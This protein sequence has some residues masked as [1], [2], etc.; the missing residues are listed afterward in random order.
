MVD[1]IRPQ[2]LPPNEDQNKD[3]PAKLDAEPAQQARED[4]PVQPIR[5]YADTTHI[6]NEQHGFVVLP[7][8]KS[9]KKNP[10]K[11]VADKFNNLS[12]KQKIIT[13]IALVLVVI[14]AGGGV[15]ALTRDKPA[16]PPPP[17]VVE[18]KVEKPKPTTEASSLTGV[19]VPIGSNKRPITSIQI[20]NSPDARPQSGLRDAGVVF[21]AI[22]EGGITRFNA[23]FQEAKP[24]YIGP[25]RSVR[26]YYAELAA[27]FDPIFVHAGGSAAGLAKLA[28]LQ[29][30]DLD[31]GAN[32]GAF[33]R[34][35][36]RYAPHNLYSSTAALDQ[37][38]AS[39][40]YTKSNA[41]G[42]ER[43]A[44]K[45]GQPVKA[46]TINMAISSYLYNTTYNYDPAANN[47]QRVMAGQPHTDH[48]S[49]K[50]ITPKVVI[51]I[52]SSFSQN[53]IYS[54]YQTSGAGQVFIFQDG[55][56]YQGKWHKPSPRDRITFTDAANKAIKINAGQTWITL[57]KDP[58]QVSFGP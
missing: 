35:S 12:K 13:I 38:A 44:E 24:D 49:G 28:E 2:G 10:L 32:G 3:A 5:P 57:I 29:I 53:G 47:Y 50:Q 16:P 11:A 46:K 37:A 33:Q 21:E 36:D 1:D 19:S 45:K 6:G 40:G 23:S 51:A 34:V 48:R 31:H 22:A 54:V 25:I 42:F 4:N 18:K 58:G 27:Q 41:K 43:K 14:G 20:E 56:V 52:V 15:Y 30:K 7:D 17:P 26:P 9:I 8:G 55:Q 39:R